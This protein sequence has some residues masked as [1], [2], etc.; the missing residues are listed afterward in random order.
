MRQL[1]IHLAIPNMAKKEKK[2]SATLCYFALKMSIKT[3]IH[4]LPI[5]RKIIIVF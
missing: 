4:N 1:M 3:Q 2:I 5:F